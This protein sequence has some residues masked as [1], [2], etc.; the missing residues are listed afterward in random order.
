VRVEGV[1]AWLPVG[2]DTGETDEEVA[3]GDRPVIGRQDGGI[4]LLDLD[5]DLGHGR[6]QICD[7]KAGKIFPPQKII[8]IVARGYWN[9]CDDIDAA[10]VLAL[11]K[12]V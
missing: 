2:R 8:S 4:F 10:D 12:P 3:V 1:G 7:T 5:L 11:V 6:G 9:E